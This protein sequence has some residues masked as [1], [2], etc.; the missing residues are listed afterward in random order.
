MC[1]S[2]DR[3]SWLHKMLHCG[4]STDNTHRKR[5]RERVLGK[6]ATEKEEQTRE[7]AARGWRE[8]NVAVRELKI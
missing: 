7:E 8:R 3:V 4:N 5:E 2:Q 1:F 6:A